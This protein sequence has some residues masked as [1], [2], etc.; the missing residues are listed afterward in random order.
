MRLRWR[1]F[2]LVASGR[3]TVEVRLADAKRAAIAAGD[4]VRFR[5]GEQCADTLVTGVRRYRSFTEL[6]A[7]EPLAA[8]DPSAARDEQL[9][10]LRR[11]YPPQREAL[12]VVAIGVR[13]LGPP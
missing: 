6:L 11:I 2:D 9:A 5:C 1:Y 8:L 13:L 10:N 3:K 4:T 12:G 7:H